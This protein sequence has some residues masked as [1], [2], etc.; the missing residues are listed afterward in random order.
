VSHEETPESLVAEAALR[1]AEEQ[2]S[3]IRAIQAKMESQA[4]ASWEIYSRAKNA[5]DQAKILTRRAEA[6]IAVA[7]Y[8]YAKSR[9]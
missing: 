6:L 1:V 3:E 9:E 5:V 8:E 2:L 4:Q 7:K